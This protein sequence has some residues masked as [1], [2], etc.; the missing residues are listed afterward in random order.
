[1]VFLFH[2]LFPEYLRR[3]FRKWNFTTFSYSKND[4]LV[5]WPVW[6]EFEFEEIFLVTDWQHFVQS[7]LL[8]CNVSFLK[9]FDKFLSDLKSC[10][11]SDFLLPGRGRRRCRRRRRAPPPSYF[12]FYPFASFYPLILPLEP[13]KLFVRL[14][15]PSFYYDNQQ[16]EWLI[17][18]S[19]LNYLG[20]SFRGLW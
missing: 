5:S 3:R 17:K 1:M 10:R 9:F 20:P 15:L 2:F 4:F 19:V 8:L 14:L 12:L 16:I 18:Y 11:F 6:H 13:K 7:R